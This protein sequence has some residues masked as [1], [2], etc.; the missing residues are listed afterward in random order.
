MSRAKWNRNL[1]NNPNLKRWYD[2]MCKKSKVRAGVYFRSLCRFCENYA[3]MTPSQFVGLTRRKME[4]ITMDFVT[5]M[6]GSISPKTKKPYAPLYIEGYVK[7]VSSCARWNSKKFERQITIKNINL[8]PVASSERVPTQDELGRV[9]YSH[10]TPLRTRVI[11]ALIAFGGAR[12]KSYGDYEGLDGIK[13]K[14]FPELTIAKDE[15]TGK[16]K[17]VNFAEAP[18]QIVI[19]S[20]LSKSGLEY[21]TFL[22]EEGM[23]ILKQYLDHRIQSG[24]VLTPES[25]IIVTCNEDRKRLLIPHSRLEVEDTSPFICSGK[26]GDLVRQA[27]RLAG[28]P[29]RPYIFRSYFDSS[30]ATAEQKGWGSHMRSSNFSWDMWATSRRSTR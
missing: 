14:D 5:Q 29:W 20:N 24:E 17:E 12:F 16:Q 2:S 13:I 8:G 11:I 1:E 6:E 10:T 15:E 19:R 27:M 25:G 3:K 18:T 28:L 21:R 30:L 7:A 9:L 4:D 23:E 26:V 22:A